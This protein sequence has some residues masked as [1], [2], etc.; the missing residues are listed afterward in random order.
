[1]D[2]KDKLKAFL[3]NV[4]LQFSLGK[5]EAISELERQKENL[6]KNIDSISAKISESSDKLNETDAGKKLND[7]IEEL[8]LQLALG[9]A[10]T[11]DLFN[12]HSENLNKNLSSFRNDL[13]DKYPDLAKKLDESEDK[14]SSVIEALR[15][16]YALGKPELENNINKLQDDISSKLK[17]LKKNLDDGKEVAEEKFDDFKGEILDAL[18][19]MKNAFIKLIR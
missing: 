17:D 6:K 15:L 2:S 7:K 12:K 1:M 18:N 9:K 16:Q 14:I 3:E 13:N 10:E 8:K 4:H 5:S 11:K 19:Q